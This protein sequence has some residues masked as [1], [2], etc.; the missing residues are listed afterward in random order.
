MEIVFLDKKTVG[1]VSNF[2]LL[3]KLGNVTV[4]E[5]TQPEDVIERIV[6][7]DRSVVATMVPSA[8]LAS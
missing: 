7:D 4:Y 2:N 5:N 1:D 8:F 6:P 3:Q